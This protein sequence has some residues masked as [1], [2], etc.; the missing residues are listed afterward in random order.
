MVLDR[1]ILI[2][3]LN[4]DPLLVRQLDAWRSSGPLLIISSITITEVLSL[5]TLTPSR[6]RQYGQFLRTFQVM[7]PSE[8]IAEEAARL[9]RTYTLSVTDSLIAATA[10]DLDVPLIT[11]DAEFIRVREL[12]LVTP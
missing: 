12:S 9:R 2:G 8:A 1:N 3:Y 7:P 10:L 5:A 4:G 6:V 11:R